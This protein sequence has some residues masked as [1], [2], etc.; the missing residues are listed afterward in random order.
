MALIVPDYLPLGVSQGEKTLYQILSEKLPDDFYIWYEPISQGYLPYFTILA[1]E[2]G[3]IIIEVMG[4]YSHQLLSADSHHFTIKSQINKTEIT[5]VQPSSPTIPARRTRKRS[6]GIIDVQQSPLQQVHRYFLDQLL[7]KIKAYHILSQYDSESPNKLAFPVGIGVVMPN[8]TTT[9]SREKNLYN[10]LNERQVIYREE[11][12]SWKEISEIDL[13]N[14]LKRMFTNRFDFLPLTPD[15]IETIKG[16]LYPELAIKEIPASPCSVPTGVELREKSYVIRTLD[17]RQECVAKAIGEGHR[18]IYGVA[19]SGKTLILLCRAKL[20]ANQNPTQRILILCFNISLAFYLKSILHEDV[21]NSA[22]KTIDVFDFHSWASFLVKKL[23]ARLPGLPVD[24]CEELIGEKLLARLRSLSTHL[25]WDAVL[26][27]EAQTFFPSWLKC[28]VA[29]L[30]NPDIGNLMLVADGNQSLYKRC[31]FTWKSVGIKAVGRTISKKYYLDKNYRNT[32]EILEAAWSVVNHIYEP[33]NSDNTDTTE[34]KFPIIEPRVATR[35]GS[36][37]VLHIQQTK[38][39]EV[40]AVIKQVQQLNQIGYSLSEV[41]VLYRI[42]GDKER[43]ML[44]YLTA[45]LEHLG[46]TAYWVTQSRSSE[47]SYSINKPGVRI[48]STLNSLGLEFKAVLILWVQD[49]EF[50]IPANSETDALTCRRLYVAMTRAQDVLHIFGS[51]NSF[52][53]EQLKRSLAFATQEG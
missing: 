39:Q 29:A 41:G 1:P 30:K 50:T 46:L 27:D 19:G 9:Q 20:L 48:M 35:K 36:R 25:K 37:P 3:L 14:R 16:V 44:N 15:Q 47:R 12:L 32:Q 53:I 23:P 40:E 43:Q 18:V 4:W 34:V 21:H 6:R 24:Y 7:D 2:F 49:W 5:E 33:I 26:V 42:A 10:F 52:L 11:F 31:G 8:I 51:G 28:C 38:S 22:F 45:Q 13:V 17:H